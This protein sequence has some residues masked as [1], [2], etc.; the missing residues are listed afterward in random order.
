MQKKRL[1]TYLPYFFFKPLQETNKKIL[2]LIHVCVCIPLCVC[3]SPMNY[4][5]VFVFFFIVIIVFCCH[6]FMPVYVN[7]TWNNLTFCVCVWCCNCHFV[8]V[9]VTFY[10]F[11]DKT[12]RIYW[13]CTHF[14]GPT[15]FLKHNKK[16]HCILL[17]DSIYFHL[18][19]IHLFQNFKN[20]LEHFW[21]ETCLQ[22]CPQKFSGPVGPAEVLK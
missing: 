7:T 17:T 10:K 18:F 22:E 4:P 12:N 11:E 2:G 3:E 9:F 13:S 21:G 6:C 15:I 8:V 14:K 5:I 16:K 20:F 1:L 19:Y